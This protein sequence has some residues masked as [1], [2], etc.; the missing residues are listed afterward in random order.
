MLNIS[1]KAREFLA[2]ALERNPGSDECFRLTRGA[3]G[4]I[5]MVYGR[6]VESDVTIDHDDKTVLALEPD[7][8]ESLDGKTIDLQQ[9]PEGK[10]D[11]VLV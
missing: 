9:A 5:A 4:R 2:G 11:L 6:P 3:S 8:A 10:L 1:D 7:L